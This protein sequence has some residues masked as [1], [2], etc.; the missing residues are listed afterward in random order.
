MHA[1]NRITKTISALAILLVIAGILVAI[2]GVYFYIPGLRESIR[3]DTASAMRRWFPSDSD[4][5]FSYNISVDFKEQKCLLK[6]LVVTKGT[7]KVLDNV[8]LFDYRINAELVELDLNPLL[9]HQPLSIKDLKGFRLYGHMTS[10][11]LQAYFTPENSGMRVHDIGY[12]DFTEKTI[13]QAEIFE[14][15]G[16]E[17]MISGRWKIDENGNL[18][19]RDRSYRNP[20]GPVGSDVIQFIEKHSDPTLKFTIFSIPLEVKDYTFDGKTLSLELERE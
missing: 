16:I 14:M 13:I 1:L 17:A 8:S 4:G 9:K 19:L 11:E 7:G 15:Q 2:W 3:H 18:A 6:N 20:D 10:G 5:E 12:D